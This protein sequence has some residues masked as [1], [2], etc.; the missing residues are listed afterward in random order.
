MG[1]GLLQFLNFDIIA[2]NKKKTKKKNKIKSTSEQMVNRRPNQLKQQEMTALFVA[3]THN[4][5][6]LMNI[7]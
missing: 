3:G 7:A 4:L 5:H 1:E 6:T 2:T